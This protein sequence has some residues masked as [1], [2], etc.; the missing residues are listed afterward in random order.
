MKMLY[1]PIISDIGKAFIAL[2]MVLDSWVYELISSSYR[3]FMALSGARLL[4][5]DAFSTIANKLYIIVG[6][7]MLFVLSYAIIKAIIDPDQMTKGDLGGPKIIKG[8]L[9]A[10]I[11]LGITPVLFNMLYQA[12]GVILENNVLGELFFRS[13]SY[14]VDLQDTTYVD[15]DGNEIKIEYN[16]DT[17][18]PDDILKSS[19]GALVATHIWQAFFYPASGNLEDAKNIESAAEDYLNNNF[20]TAATC[21]VTA[22][23]ATGIGLALAGFTGGISLLI[24]GAAAIAGASCYA[25]SDA[26][27]E[28]YAEIINGKITL[29]Q[30]YVMSASQGDF[31]IYTTFLDEVSG[32]D[33]T[34][35]YVMVISTIVGGVVLYA[36][37][38]FSIDMGV[39]C[40]KLAYYQIIAPIP[41]ILQV[42]PKFKDS[43]NKYIKGVLSTFLEV[44][45]RISVVYVMVYIICHIT[46]LFSTSGVWADLGPVEGLFA[47]VLLDVGLVIFA[48]QAPKLIQETFG[49]Q[50][51]SM[52]LGIGKKLAD[53]G[54][55]ALGGVMGAGVMGAVNGF[56]RKKDGLNMGQRVTG[57][58]GGTA[59][60]MWSGIRDNKKKMAD[61]FGSMTE[62]WKN[63]GA[64]QR[65]KLEEKQ[66]LIA[67]HRKG[68]D[69]SATYAYVAG[70]FDNAKRKTRRFVYGASNVD[71]EK[72][73]MNVMSR[74]NDLQGDLR[75]EAEKKDV[76]TK[77]LKDRYEKLSAKKIDE[78][79]D[80]WTEESYNEELRRRLSL[81][82]DAQVDDE[83]SRQLF[84]LESNGK[85]TDATALNN[86]HN[87]QAA[88]AH[89]EN[90]QKDLEALRNK[91]ADPSLSDAEKNN[92]SNKI[93]I[94][95]A[96]LATHK[97][98][99]EVARNNLGTITT[100]DGDE[101][102]VDT[103][104]STVRANVT[105]KFKDEA[106]Y[107]ESELMQLQ[108]EHQKAV[109]AAKAAYETAA[110]MWV[111]K[112]IMVGDNEY[113]N[114]TIASSMESIFKD[115][116]KGGNQIV[117][118]ANGKEVRVEDMVKEF[119]G[120]SV[121]DD[122][123]FDK[124]GVFKTNFTYKLGDVEVEMLIDD[125]DPNDIKCKY[126]DKNDHS[127]EYTETQ[128]AD[129][130]N[131][132]DDRDKFSQDT[133]IDNAKKIGKK[134]ESYIRT[135]AYANKV[136]EMEE[137]NKDKK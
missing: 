35:D 57:A 5:S 53:G 58:L 19:G 118:D 66:N 40:A 30:A 18:N 68:E 103:A 75:N 92:I 87:Y 29:E 111:N 13:G 79:K 119:Y 70:K 107:N 126:V 36:F 55:M 67:E 48:K 44:F 56:G 82:S 15:K 94:A 62:Q 42:L 47:R 129:Y 99:L 114:N 17:I 2:L 43:F 137:E 34:I 8:V 37:I 32:D 72:A 135:N 63:A 97:A 110:D 16:V 22:G 91:L 71:S 25:A 90:K 9:I 11:G 52:S 61:S 77:A 123:K 112:K 65:E 76:T 78:Y 41:L 136:K 95:E 6:V 102:T 84:K 23:A 89:Y 3:V 100:V 46:D 83:L 80:G 133:A 109:D 128:I 24:A 132:V 121:V 106:K 104:R 81:I 51:G 96:E 108:L 98:D 26:L 105:A 120:S 12:Q 38:S 134:G 101:F 33:A 21:A 86:I 130:I 131:K 14:T 20:G 59:R 88:M 54:L 28:A 7:V 113:I 85:I 93:S 69:G 64:Y 60:G 116:K 74:M 45:I 115:L 125:S 50:S 117:L 124:N 4:S 1:I 10:V 122:G 31:G 127:I 73:A 39:R 27:D 49:I